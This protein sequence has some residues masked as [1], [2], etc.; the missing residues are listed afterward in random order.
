[1]TTRLVLV[2]ALAALLLSCGSEP[3][4][5]PEPPRKAAIPKPRDE[6]SRFPQANL[7]GTQLIDTQLMGKPFMPGGTLANYKK[8]KTKYDMF[9]AKAPT[10]N[11]AALALLDWKKALSSARLIPSF[12]GYFGEDQGR[13]VFVFS[14]DVWIAG[15]AGLPE[16][17]ADLQARALAAHL[18]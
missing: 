15:V 3:K 8:G 5:A 6:S 7:T 10:P 11:D 2:P 16:K 13:S 4:P 17:E 18:Q 9:I 12:G 14:K 1:M